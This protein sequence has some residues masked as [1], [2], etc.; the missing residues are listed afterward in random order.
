MFNV[1]VPPRISDNSD[2]VVADI[3]LPIDDTI[4]H[5]IVSYSICLDLYAKEKEDSII[6]NYS[7]N[8]LISPYQY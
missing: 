2:I 4:L 6:L 5:T 8:N 3:L 1:T 7:E